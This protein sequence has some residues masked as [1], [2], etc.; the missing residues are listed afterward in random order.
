MKDGL[1]IV[2]A[3]LAMAVILA[4]IL[5]YENNKDK[6]FK[7]GQIACINGEIHYELKDVPPV[8]YKIEKDNKGGWVWD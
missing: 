7:A 2:I 1:H 3:F 4:M 5:L 6:A 8:W